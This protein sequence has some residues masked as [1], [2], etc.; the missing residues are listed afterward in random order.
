MPATA[1]AQVELSSVQPKPVAAGW[2][3]FASYIARKHSITG[4]ILSPSP[5]PGREKSLR[6]L[7]SLTELSETDFA[8]EVASFYKLP[9]LDL[10]QLLETTPL[11]ARFSH[12]FL[13]EALIYPCERTGEQILVVS[14]PTDLAAIRAAELVFKKKLSLVIAS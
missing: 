6:E 11:T 13:R 8:D 2:L 1:L 7:F 10:A 14:D 4:D 3:D 5:Q 12:R 9:R